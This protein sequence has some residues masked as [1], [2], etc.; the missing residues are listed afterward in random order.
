MTLTTPKRFLALGLAAAFAVAACG[1]GGGSAAPTSGASDGGSAPTDGASAPAESQAAGGGIPDCL[2]FADIYALVGPES[3]GFANWSEAQTIASELGSTTTFPDLPLSITAPGEESGTFDSFVELAIADAAEA[4][5]QDETT[6]PDYTASSNDNAIIEGV[7]QSAGSF[8]WVGFAFY[9]ENSEQVRTLQIS[10]EAGGTCVEPTA[11]T[12][13]SNEYPLARD[14]YIYVNTAKAA[15]NPAVAAYVDYYVA[16][17]TIASALE[18][19]PYV[20]LTPDA[21]AETQAAWTGAG[22]TGADP[23]GTVFVTGSSTVEPISNSVAEA[24]KAANA[25][26][27]YTVEGPGTGDGFAK[28]CA[29]E[30]D[31]ADASRPIREEEAQTCAG[32]GIEYVE[33]KVAI[34]GIA[35]IT[36]P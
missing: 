32:A 15:E 10:E 26:F 14:L 20:N 25:G 8:G 17:G 6:R 28:F 19:V 12:I 1:G 16:E 18:T 2:S 11:E 7:A 30:A 31:I 24:F 27:D 33:L 3:T 36:Q 22:V 13:A 29:G 21:L 23:N 34:D 35:V 9:Q 4:R 5:T